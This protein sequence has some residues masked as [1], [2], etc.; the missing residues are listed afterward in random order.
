MTNM[1]SMKTINITTS[2][3]VQLTLEQL[4][5][6][7][8]T[9]LVI[10]SAIG[11]KR[12]LYHALAEFLNEHDIAV[13]LYNFRGME[14]QQNLD[15]VSSNAESWGQQDQ[16]AV[17][18]WA[19][20]QLKPEKLYVLGHSIGGQ[21]VGFAHN[22]D[23]VD[24]VIHVASQKGDK[25]LWPWPG[26]IKLF[27]LWHVLIPFMSRG[28]TF[29]ARK[30]GLG[31]YPWPAAAAAQWASWGQ[32]SDYLFNSKFGFD[33]SPWHHFDK[34][35]L[36]F[37]FS[38]DDMAP[39]ASIDGLLS[40]FGKNIYDLGHIEKRII[41]PQDIGLKAIGHFGFFKPSAKPLWQDLATWIHK[42]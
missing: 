16:S 20:E 30:L 8:Q 2:D 26:R 38:D 40:E 4:G 25:R 42:Q 18:D 14:D 10:N 21:L 27:M 31:S 41:N 1:Y 17:I 11:V 28:K 35:L 23:Q 5:D 32:Q 13:V 6:D 9:T 15:Q 7:C 29:N 12:K 19:K 24:G 33:L 39:E 37:G 22:F 3:H 36:S 34:P